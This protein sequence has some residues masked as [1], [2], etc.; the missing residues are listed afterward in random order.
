MVEVF[1]T[2]HSNFLNKG[3]AMFP[4]IVLLSLAAGFL[5]GC[6]L[7]PSATPTPEIVSGTAIRGVA[8]GG[9]QA[10]VGAKVYVLA[11]NNGGYGGAS[12][13]LLNAANTGNAADTI[14]SYVTTDSGGFFSVTGDYTCTAG[15]QLYLYVL[16]GNTGSGTNSASGLMAVLGACGSL[17]P[18]VWVNEVTT[19]AAAYAMAGY[20]VDATHVA[21]SGTAQALTGVANAFANSTN[22]VTINTG[23]ARATTVSGSGAVP[24][25]RINTLANIL[26]ACVNTTGAASTQCATLFSNAKSAGSTGTQPTETATAAINIAHNAGNAASTLYGLQA[27]VASPFVPNL[28]SAPNDLLIPIHHTGGGL[29]Q[30]FGLAVD[31]AGT[32][33]VSNINGT[34][35]NV[36]KITASGV[37]SS[38]TGAPPSQIG[39]AVDTSGNVWF[40][41]QSANSGVGG[42]AKYVPGGSFTLFNSAAWDGPQFAAIDSAGN[43]WAANVGLNTNGEITKLTSS[44]SAAAGSPFTGGSPFSCLAVAI[45][46]G[47]NAWV[48]NAG[49]GTNGTINRYSSSGVPAS[50][51]GYRDPST[52]SPQNIALDAAGFV[53]TADAV[54]SSVQKFL[55][56]GGFL[57]NFTGG[58]LLGAS[59][60]SIAI[61]GAGNVWTGSGFNTSVN[62][63]VVEL[64]NAGVALSPSGGFTDTHF[65]QILTIAVDSS[66]DVWAANTGTNTV[67]ELIGA[68]TPV[69]TPMAANLSAPYGAPASR[70]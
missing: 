4:R 22:L 56:T 9:Q 70:P 33:W 47:G 45:D 34:T 28:S 29:N 1:Q 54:G 5:T 68:A 39:V 30:P 42:A 62:N 10:I 13:S 16:G 67:S 2:A 3:L 50:S 69:V 61:D 15:Q 60:T 20:A 36:T 65:N 18:S 41:N 12:L 37:V 59:P 57:G 64:N 21:S 66:G 48:A 35:G 31:A 17:A 46:A 6:S 8:H 58:G 51:T 26:A 55:S 25:T 40:T 24:Q 23:V 49:S 19:V 43:F 14:G 52:K 63:R 32:V 44:G 53:W 38:I 7:T 27:G 11:A